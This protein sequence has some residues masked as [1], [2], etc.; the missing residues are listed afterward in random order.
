[1][2]DTAE[3]YK[4]NSQASLKAWTHPSLSEQRML[5][6]NC[7]RSVL[8]FHDWLPPMILMKYLNPSLP[9]C[10]CVYVYV[11]RYVCSLLFLGKHGICVCVRVCISAYICIRLACTIKQTCILHNIPRMIF[12]ILFHWE[13]HKDIYCAFLLMLDDISSGMEFLVINIIAE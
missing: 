11:A 8:H 2:E 7:N 1:M 4:K 9:L 10:R 3:R 6:S 5:G 12:S 13:I